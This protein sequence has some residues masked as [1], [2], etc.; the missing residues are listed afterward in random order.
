MVHLL[1][2]PARSCLPQVGLSLVL[3]QRAFDPRDVL[4][5]LLGGGVG[6]EATTLAGDALPAAVVRHQR[7][8]DLARRHLGEL[9]AG[10]LLFFVSVHWLFLIQSGE[11]G[12]ALCPARGEVRSLPPVP[13]DRGEYHQ[14][15]TPR[16]PSLPIPASNW[17]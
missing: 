17:R 3:T 16:F 2:S 6:E 9:I 5:H 7:P 1:L 11:I 14:W 13:L 8:K 15:R 12:G 4:S 10:R